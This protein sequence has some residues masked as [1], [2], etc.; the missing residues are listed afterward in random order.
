VYIFTKKWSLKLLDDYCIFHKNALI[1]R[2]YR[3]HDY[4]C[5]KTNIQFLAVFLHGS[6]GQAF[7][8]KCFYCEKFRLK[9]ANFSS[10]TH[11][12]MK[13]FWSIDIS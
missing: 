10:V 5:V 13:A 9:S 4:S 11:S 2:K 6:V 1:I 7:N 3:H 12:H 8:E